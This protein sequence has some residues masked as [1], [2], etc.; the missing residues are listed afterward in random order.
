M[1]D[2]SVVTSVTS[3]TKFVLPSVGN[4]G[5]VVVLLDTGSVLIV[6]A[7]GSTIDGNAGANGIVASTAVT[8]LYSN[9]TAWEVLSGG[10]VA[11]DLVT[12][13]VVPSTDTTY[14]S[15]PG[16][17]LLVTP[18][19]SGTTVY[20]SPVAAG[21]PVTVKNVTGGHTV[22][23]EPYSGDT[24]TIDGASTYA[25]P[26]EYDTVT[27]ISDGSHWWVQSS[28]LDTPI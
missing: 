17:F 6:T 9:G 4:G 10:T 2:W 16:T 12:T 23:L 14:Q 26:H 5:P 15:A 18:N 11:V 3:G 8:V 24:T 21:G 19:S 7:D 22:T 25:L 1:P 13:V 20:L 27:L 28:Q